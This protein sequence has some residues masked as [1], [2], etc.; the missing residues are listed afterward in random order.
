MGECTA[1]AE[2]GE[3]EQVSQPVSNFF[4]NGFIFY[5]IIYKVTITFGNWS[6]VSVHRVVHT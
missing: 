2:E 1:T 3:K 5:I 6:T 4:I